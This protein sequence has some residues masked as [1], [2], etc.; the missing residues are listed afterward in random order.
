MLHSLYNFMTSCFMV[1]H[2]EIK[3]LTCRLEKGM[4][5]IDFTKNLPQ[6]ASFTSY[7]L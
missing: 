7:T 6:L 5:M 4:S 2:V 3:K 1:R